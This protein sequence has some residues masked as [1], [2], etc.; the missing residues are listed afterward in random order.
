MVGRHV[1]QEL[2]AGAVLT[3]SVFRAG[4]PLASLIGDKE[5]A[6]AIAVDEVSG[7]GGFIQPGDYV[8]VL[9]YL[10]QTERQ[11]VKTA[12]VVIPA[13]RVL[14][15]GEELSVGANGEPVRYQ[16]EREDGRASGRRRPVQTAVLAVPAPLITRFMLASEVG[17]L[18][19]AVRSAE[20]K[21]LADYFANGLRESEW[22]NIEHQL[23]RFEQLALKRTLPGRYSTRVRHSGLSRSRCL[24]SVALM[25]RAE[26]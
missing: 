19:L 3:Q 20:E 21:R 13:L 6:V 26:L 25:E 1:W 10:R 4:G 18:R 15:Y 8:D 9:L 7:G 22:Q 5:R 23:F 12:Q 24:S 2:P 17:T 11:G 14:G 16:T